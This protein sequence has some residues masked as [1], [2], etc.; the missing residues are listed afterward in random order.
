M[1]TTSDEPTTAGVLPWREHVGLIVTALLFA[2][3]LLRLMVV[4]A[5]NTTT[6]LAILQRS[7]PTTALFAFAVTTAIPGVLSSA[8][9]VFV[10]TAVRSIRTSDRALRRWLATSGVSLVALALLVSWLAAL[11][12]V[13]VGGVLL[14]TDS[15]SQT[16]FPAQVDPARERRYVLTLVVSIF[17]LVT[18][19]ADAMWLPAERI[20]RTDGS[21]VVGYVLDRTD[22][23]LTVLVDGTRLVV[24]VATDTV[25]STEYCTLAKKRRWERPLLSYAHRGGDYRKCE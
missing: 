10:S 20:E 21:A 7:S 1:G 17:V 23:D 24:R 15:L 2:A 25:R 16:S 9:G 6:M 11:G 8:A 22:Y 4:S 19:T 12:A 13:V 5:F 18:V 3:F 14:V